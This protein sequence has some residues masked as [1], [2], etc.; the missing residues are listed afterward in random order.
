DFV[1]NGLVFPDRSLKPVLAECAKLF[2]PITARSAQPLSGR[3]TVRNGQHFTGLERVA[4]RWT[5]Q[6]EGEAVLTG[7]MALPEIGPGRE[8]ELDL[9]SAWT[10]EALSRVAEGESF[11]FLE[12]LT[13]DATAWSAAGHRLGWEQMPLAAVGADR[14]KHR[15]VALPGVPARLSSSGGLWTASGGGSAKSEVGAWRARFSEEGFL[16]SLAGAHGEIL[17]SALVMNLWRAP[18]EN[19]G[20]KLFIDRRGLP[21]FE[22]YYKDKV[23][24]RWIDA[25]LDRLAYTLSSMRAEPALPG[26]SIC[27]EVRTGAGLRAGRLVQE[28]RFEGSGPSCSFLFDLDA[29]LP[30]LPRIGLAC[31]LTAGF[32]EVN[33]YGLGPHECYSDRRAGAWMARHASSVDGLQV[34][35][36][37]PQEN[38]NR[39]GVREVEL[40]AAGGRTLR[41]ASAGS[42]DFSASHHGVEQLWKARHSSELSRRPETFLTLDVAQRGVGTAACGPDTL[43]RY[44]LRPGVHRLELAFT[45]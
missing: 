1:C 42:F 8:A 43:E 35:Y 45:P 4:L 6:V 10:A 14:A 16:E 9:S 37:L 17:A 2:Q 12:F 40:G 44:R 33:W 34:P 28:W 41:I 27:H 23:M 30:E 3:V 38:G 5:L 31:A 21:D 24:Y 22:F 32:E 20:L 11:L 15:P 19:D 39:T 7:T 18:T 26:L 29:A 36:V 25:G 13:S